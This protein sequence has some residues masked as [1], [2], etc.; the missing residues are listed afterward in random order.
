MGV[1]IAAAL[2]MAL[3]LAACASDEQPSTA[4][5][6]TLPASPHAC[7]ARDGSVTDVAHEPDWRQYA[8]YRPWTTPDG[9]LLRIDVVAD[10]P[11]PAHCGMEA[12]RV[13]ITG[14]P[15]G[16]PYATEQDSAHYV[17]D[18]QDAFGDPVTARAFED[19]AD[20]PSGAVDTGYRQ[21][22]ASLWVDPDDPASIYLVDGDRVERWPLDPEPAACT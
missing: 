3:V 13:I 10:R 6:P 18:P 7:Q 20:L 16:T 21:H 8:E 2:T 14:M 22:S 1:R 19:D 17:R 12:A 15:V 11:G 4:G 9:C 5:S